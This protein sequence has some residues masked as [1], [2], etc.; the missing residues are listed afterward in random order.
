MLH[1]KLIITLSFLLIGLVQNAQTTIV[2]QPGSEGKD[3]V[4]WNNGSNINFGNALNNNIYTWTNN[5]SLGLKRALIEF[6]L[7]QIP[8]NAVITS[9]LMSLYY[10][11]VDGTESYD[12]QYGDNAFFIQKVTSSWSE[13]AVKWNNQPTYTSENNVALPASSSGTQDYLDMDVTDLVID[14]LDNSNY[15]FIMKMQDEQNPYRGLLFASSDHPNAALH[16][17]LVITYIEDNNDCITLKPGAE[18]KDAAVWNNG[19]TNNGDRES[20]NIYTWTNS[21]YLGV[22]RAFLEFDLSE[23]PEDATISSA[24]M[25]LYYNPVDN[26]ESV[27]Y[28]S[29]NNA[30]YIQRVTSSWIEN[31]IIWNNQPNSTVENRVEIPASTSETQDYIDIDVIDLINDML[32][33]NNG[34][35]IRMKDE[36][37][38]YKIL[39]FASGDHPDSTLHPELKV[40]WRR[41]TEVN[42]IE[43]S[44]VFS[45]YP[46]PANGVFNVELLEAVLIGFNYN[47][48]NLNGQIVRK[49]QVTDDRF[50]IDLSNSEKGIYFLRLTN[51][52]GESWSKK[53]LLY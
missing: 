44:I 33:D 2:I 34:F 21:G 46:N 13:N 19:Q 26:L 25:S 29:G 17:K 48:I 16:P 10:N 53:L 49:G 22:K 37:N 42:E 39:L 45:V 52:K 6:D 38:P 3:A 12:Y 40:C 30:F 7:S 1:P 35:L 41:T 32:D 9:A 8:E 36:N 15:G 18:G 23:V 11:P 28:H 5:G 20:L 51:D 50:Q 47:V 31:T 14:M 43:N 24:S 27:D 4:I